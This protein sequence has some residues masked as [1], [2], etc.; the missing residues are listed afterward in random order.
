M[1][2]LELQPLPVLGLAAVRPPSLLL[3]LLVTAQ[4]GTQCDVNARW[5][6]ES[7]ALGHLDEVQL[8]H[9]EHGA[10]RVG[11]VRLQV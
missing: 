6:R 3:L 2:A 4:A 1:L 9:I 5:G 11:G 7:E 8:V 10:K